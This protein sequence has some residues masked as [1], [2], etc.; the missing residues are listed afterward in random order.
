MLGGQVP[1]FSNTIAHQLFGPATSIL[2]VLPFLLFNMLVNGEE[3]GWRGY[4]LPRLQWRHNALISSLII[5]VIWTTWHIPK[6]LVAGDS[7]PFGW[8]LIMTVARAILFTWVYNGTRGSLLLVTLFHAAVNTAYVFL[9]VAPHGV[10]Q[11]RIYVL[12]VVIECVAALAVTLVAGPRNL[13]RI[14]PAQVEASDIDESA[15]PLTKQGSNG[16]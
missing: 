8:Y 6:F 13:S 16:S 14:Y 15:N 12:A 7:T 2:F 10:G 9:P 1:D 3:I 4:V 11:E 5:G